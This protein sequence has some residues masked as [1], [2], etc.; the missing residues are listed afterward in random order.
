MI[1]CRCH[2][3][4][5]NCFQSYASTLLGLS[6]VCTSDFFMRNVEVTPNIPRR[7]RW[8]AEVEL[9]SFTSMLGQRG[10]RLVVN[11]MPGRFTPGHELRFPLYRWLGVPITGVDGCREENISCLRGSN[12]ELR[13]RNESLYRPLLIVCDNFERLENGKLE[14][15]FK[16]VNVVWPSCCAV[17]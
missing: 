8:G 10:G 15:H 11:A 4:P 14:S 9:C 5:Q 17:L 6:E 3:I 16:L 2:I 1:Y 13:D 7:H 12:L